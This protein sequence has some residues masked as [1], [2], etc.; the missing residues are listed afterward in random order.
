MTMISGTGLQRTKARLA[1]QRVLAWLK[2]ESRYSET[3][4]PR[5]MDY[6]IKRSSSSS[7]NA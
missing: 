1:S 3:A 2:E 7:A 4:E 6:R 5:M